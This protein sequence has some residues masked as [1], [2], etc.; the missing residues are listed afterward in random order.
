MAH[1]CNQA[2]HSPSRVFTVPDDCSNDENEPLDRNVP[3]K[4]ATDVSGPEIN[5]WKEEANSNHNKLQQ[6]DGVIEIESTSD[7]DIFAARLA[8][9]QSLLS[10]RRRF[11]GLA[12][13]GA[14]F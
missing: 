5:P 8:E 4:I 3:R 1:C 9:L 12:L 2:D 6:V 7:S 14:S 11:E 10:S 13:T